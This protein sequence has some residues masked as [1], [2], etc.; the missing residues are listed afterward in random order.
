MQSIQNAHTIYMDRVLPDGDAGSG[1]QMDS[2]NLIFIVGF[3]LLI[4]VLARYLAR[5]GGRRR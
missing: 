4:S 1:G 5:R 2:L 3:A